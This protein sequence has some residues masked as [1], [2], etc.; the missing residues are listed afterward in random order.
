MSGGSTDGTSK[1]PGLWALMAPV[2]GRIWLAMGVAAAGSA[3]ALLAVAAMALVVRALH[4]AVPLYVTGLA[5]DVPALVIAALVLTG[6]ALLLRSMA[7]TIAHRAAFALELQLRTRLADHLA[8]LPLGDVLTHGSGALKKILL[9]DVKGLHVFVA[10]STPFMG[11]SYMSPIMTVLLLFALDWRLALAAIGVFALAVLAMG[12][13]MRDFAKLRQRYDDG[14]ERINAAVVEFVQAMPVVRTFDTGSGT[15]HRYAAALTNFRDML[16]GWIVAMGRP[17]SIAMMI[18]SPL[19]TLL[20]VSALGIALYLAGSVSFAVLMA[21]WLLSTGLAESLMPLMWLMNMNR[22]AEIGAIRINEFLARPQLS[23]TERPE[24]PKDASVC[25]DRVD[26]RY[27]NRTERALSGVSFTAAPGTITALVGRS[28]SGKSTL[29][30]L[31]PRFFDVD[32][33]EVRVGGVDVRRCQS[34][35]LMRHVSFV[36]QDPFLFHDTIAENIRIARPDASDQAVEQ[37][38]RDAMAHDFITALPQGYATIAGD[39]GARLSGGQRQRITIARAI[40]RDAPILV[41]DEATAFADPEN[42]ARIIGALAHLMRGRTVIIIAHRLST[43]R[44]ADQILV[45]DQGQVVEKG[46]HQELIE[47]EG[48]YARL[49]RS[50]KEAEGWTLGSFEQVQPQVTGDVIDS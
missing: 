43:I 32:E 19:P 4:E 22:M 30:R 24:T 39:R 37:A 26:F 13:A 42:E 21:F 2:K 8:K 16:A 6:L 12:F 28:G 25:F 3:C 50:H 5:W 35:T 23:E 49:S 20:A 41:L 45:L 17:A 44:G 36:F 48:L 40:L 27:P 31:I 9:D 7:F 34:D 29:A 38:A 10:D 14:N 18:M 33:G 1:L 47:S 46:R 15:F 11:R